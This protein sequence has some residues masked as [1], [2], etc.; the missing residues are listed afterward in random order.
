[1]D[2]NERQQ[3]DFNGV[4]PAGGPYF[5]APNTPI[6]LE[7]W[8]GDPGEDHGAQWIMAHPLAGEA[9]T[10]LVVSNHYKSLDYSVGCVEQNGPPIPCPGQGPYYRYGVT[11][12][13]AGLS[14]VHFN[15]Q[16]GGNT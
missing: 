1:M 8:F 13:N 5:L 16:G 7:V 11:I 12:T 15:L 6:I 14:A 2:F 3:A 10:K 9:P 4:Q